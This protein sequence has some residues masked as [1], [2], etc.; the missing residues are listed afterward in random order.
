MSNSTEAWPPP[1][2]FWTDT[3]PEKTDSMTRPHLFKGIVPASAANA[4]AVLD[5]F[6]A[7]RRAHAA[8]REITANARVYVGE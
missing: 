6:A 8:G 2:A 3:L 7:I 1:R 4:D 5:G